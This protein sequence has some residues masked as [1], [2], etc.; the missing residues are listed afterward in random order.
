MYP[1]HGP[2]NRSPMSSIEAVYGQLRSLNWD[3]RCRGGEGE[4][5]E[6]GALGFPRDSKSVEEAKRQFFSSLRSPQP[7]GPPER[8]IERDEGFSFSQIHIGCREAQEA[9]G[10][11]QSPAGDASSVTVQ[12]NVRPGACIFF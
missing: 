4:T 3:R 10:S 5:G 9:R 11:F 7:N 8:G 12:K 6:I 2:S 1:S